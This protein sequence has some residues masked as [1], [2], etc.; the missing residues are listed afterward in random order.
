MTNAGRVS[1]QLMT[2]MMLGVLFV[3]LAP[4]NVLA[5]DDCGGGHYH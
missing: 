2:A 1:T 3:F 4:G 5:A